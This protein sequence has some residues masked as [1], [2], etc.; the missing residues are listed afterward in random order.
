[1]KLKN[2]LSSLLLSV[3]C[4]STAL[5]H[6]GHHEHSDLADAVIHHVTSV[7]HSLMSLAVLGVLMLVAGLL[8]SVKKSA[9]AGRIAAIAQQ[10][11]GAA[12]SLAGAGLLIGQF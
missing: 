1:M 9:H 2:T 4:V 10:F 8:I 3:F 12:L 7:Y 11:T 6:P 5:A